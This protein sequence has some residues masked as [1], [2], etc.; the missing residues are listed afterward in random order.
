ME[1]YDVVGQVLDLLQ[2]QKRVSYRA[3]KRQFS[4]DDDY[5]EDLKEEIIYAQ[6]VAKDEDNRVLV[7]IGETGASPESV[8][9]PN[10]PEH[11]PV[12]EQAQSV[13]ETQSIEPH[14]PDAERRQLTVM[15]VDL[16][17]STR[18][19]SELDPSNRSATFKY[20]LLN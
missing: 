8:S 4:I 5:I 20:T 17:D 16:V 2:R 19:S 3:L 6:Q 11:H 7:W 1:F 12:V 15:F 13:Q 18:L 9:Q 10:Q 14:T